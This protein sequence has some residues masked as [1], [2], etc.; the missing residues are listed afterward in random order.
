MPIIAANEQNDARGTARLLARAVSQYIKNPHIGADHRTALNNA[1]RLL[2]AYRTNAF[3][4]YEPPLQENSQ[5]T[6]EAL[7]LLPPIERHVSDVRT[8]LEKAIS[9]VFADAP[10]EQ[11]ID[12][13]ENVLRAIVNPKKFR[14]PSPELRMK[15]ATV[16]ERLCQQ[17]QLR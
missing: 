9:E 7:T 5:E 12:T 11:A 1:F 13:I 2:E 3:F 6:T 17:L 16:F 10:E 8:A 4:G 14:S 15:T